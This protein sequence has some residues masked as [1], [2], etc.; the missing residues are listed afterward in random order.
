MKF[1]CVQLC[2]VVVLVFR[3][4]IVFLVIFTLTRLETAIVWP[5]VSVVKF[6]HHKHG[7]THGVCIAYSEGSDSCRLSVTYR[8]LNK[9]IAHFT[10]T[11]T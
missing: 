10:A 7:M 11:C 2:V 6:S 5:I 9:S 8:L 4:F 3:C 1:Y